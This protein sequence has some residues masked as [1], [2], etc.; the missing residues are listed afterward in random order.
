[1]IKKYIFIVLCS[2]YFLPFLVLGQEI[3]QPQQMHAD[4]K[5][6]KHALEIAHPS[7]YAHLTPSEFDIFFQGLIERTS[8]PL[9]SVQFHNIVLQ[10]IARLH[11]GHTQVFANKALR[12][13]LN[14]Q[15][16]LP[17]H[18]HV[19][20][21]RIF[22][23]RNMSGKVIEDG[24]E[25][26]AINGI[27]SDQ[28]IGELLKH[29]SGDGLCKSSIE[30][31]F[32]S[33]YQSFYQVFPMIFGF[34][35]TYDLVIR[36]YKTKKIQAI[37]IPVVSWGDFRT[38]ELQK[39]G[40]N[41]HTAS[42]EEV[43]AQEAFS[44]NFRETEHYAYLKIS[45]FFKDDFYEPKTTYPDFYRNVFR[46]IK[47]KGTKHLIIDLRGNGG[48]I[49]SNAAH[50]VQYLSTKPF[51]PTKE[52]S[53]QGNDEYYR[54][55]TKDS[56]ELDDYFGLKKAINGKYLVSNSDELVELKVFEPI[57]D[58]SFKGSVFVLINGGSLSAA[59]IAAGLLREYSNAIFVGQETGGYAGMSN[60]IRQL[61][62]FGDSTNLAINLPLI[63]G[64]SNINEHLKKR[65]VVPD[66]C[67]ENSID[68]ILE[69]KDLV[70][71]FVLHKI[72]NL[73]KK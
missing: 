59:G 55:L 53:L 10:F 63:H 2:V 58:L 44:I 21:E 26:I 14:Q 37:E 22:L 19:Q 64:E 4:L 40:N 73:N 6:F 11:D 31:R 20:N 46:Q 5:K 34:Q 25:I 36:D 42:M 7:L 52:L 62:I 65:G 12:S 49:G 41:L 18:V 28:I 15:K 54:V 71:D 70:L 27:P 45:R 23:T 29:F 68:A 24:S 57:V 32:G 69:K 13:Y 35:P 3:Y 43:L 51:T 17:L 72:S 67:V 48:G 66:Y 60:G 56:L 39:Y 1:M 33:S 30:Y 47:E 9:N 38:V 8:V 16:I 50:L 61:T